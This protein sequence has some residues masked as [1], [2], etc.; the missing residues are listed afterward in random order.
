MKSIRLFTILFFISTHFA[1]AQVS[2][3]VRAGM[4]LA[5]YAVSDKPAIGEVERKSHPFVVVG[6]VAEYRVNDNFAV[7]PELNFLQKGV[8]QD[9]HLTSAALGTY[10]IQTE[11][12]I[13]YLEI[14]LLIKQ[15]LSLGMLRA[16]V[17]FGPSIGYA[18]SGKGKNTYTIE[19]VTEVHEDKLDFKKAEYQRAEFGFHLDAALS[20]KVGKS[21]RIFL[22]GRYLMGLTN[23]NSSGNDGE[24]RNRG[25]SISVGTLV[26]L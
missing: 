5:N 26:A 14:P 10:R 7:Q 8:N 1:F 19:G 24:V 2:V 23:L 21:A 9:V 3:G 16:D 20:L 18:L 4:H 11:A 25:V 12:R 15:G 22:D 6:V 13:S 17:L